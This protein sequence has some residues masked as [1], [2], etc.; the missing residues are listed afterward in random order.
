MTKTGSDHLKRQARQI[1]R[2]SGRRYPDV[3][4]ELRDAPRRAPSSKE[5]VLR[6]SS[7]IVPMYGGRCA[8]PDGHPG[9]R[10]WCGPEP[11][12]AVH[13]WQGYTEARDAAEHA[14]HEAWLAGLS[15][16]ER[17]EYEAEQ[18]AAYQV[19]TAYQADMAGE[20]ESYDPDD[21]RNA[22]YALDAADEAW[23]EAEM[24][25]RADDDGYVQ[26]TN[27]EYYGTYDDEDPR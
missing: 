10:T 21:E 26:I 13:V 18:E 19:Y 15:P 22:E 6:C 8:Q 4:A 27:E 7:F 17:A 2:T 24:D 11:H 25:E 20:G 16:T 3:L 1:A 23:W 12:F 14:K 5:L 9:H